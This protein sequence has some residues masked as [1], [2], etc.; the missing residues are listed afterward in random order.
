MNHVIKDDVKR[1]NLSKGV[2]PRD[3]EVKMRTW[4]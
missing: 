4:V 1:R 2:K 3:S